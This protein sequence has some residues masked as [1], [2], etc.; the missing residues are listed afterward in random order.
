[1]KEGGKRGVTSAEGTKETKN[2]IPARLVTGTVQERES[3]KSYSCRTRKKER[4]TLCG[5][6]A[7]LIGATKNRGGL[8]RTLKS[9]EESLQHGYKGKQGR[10]ALN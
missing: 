3:G 9:K 2:F 5:E 1:M 10:T 4:D 7:S 6:G 8:A